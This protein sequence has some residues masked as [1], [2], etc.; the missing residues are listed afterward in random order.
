MKKRWWSNLGRKA[1]FVLT[2]L[3]TLPALFY[4]E[5]NW[6]GARAWTACQRAL[7]AQGES[8]D[9][10]VFLG[11]PVPLE[12][13]LATLPVFTRWGPY[14]VEPETGRAFFEHEP[15]MEIFHNMPG[16]RAKLER[17]SPGTSR[18]DLAAWQ[19]YFQSKH[20]GTAPLDPA[21]EVLQGLEPFETFLNELTAARG[22]MPTGQFRRE[23]SLAH[24]DGS[25]ASVSADLRVNF[26][27]LLRAKAL[28]AA[29]HPDEAMRDLET[30][31]WLRRA[32]YSHPPMLLPLMMGTA[33]MAQ[34]YLVMKPGMESGHWTAEEI[35]RLQKEL[36][37]V[38][39]LADYVHAM[40]GE[41]AHMLAMLSARPESGALPSPN[42]LWSERL[43][44]LAFLSGPSGWIDQNKANLCQW[45]QDGPLRA[46]D[47][48]GHRIYPERMAAAHSAVEIRHVWSLPYRYITANFVYFLGAQLF[49]VADTQA[50]TDELI[51]TCALER[52]ALTHGGRIPVALTELVP[53]FLDRLPTNIFDGT[54]PRYQIRP[55]GSYEL[56]IKRPAK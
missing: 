16:A 11:P 19:Q 53:H 27:L 42:E 12:R 23:Y 34:D 17:S 49:V 13:N 36:E 52:Y 26:T 31:C 18:F 46:C 39:L 25:Y 7:A 22:T 54:P 15:L 20:P 37:G 32:L 41:R 51:V 38:D 33:L 2:L 55:D 14:T 3:T 8:L 6:R 30:A 48:P 35:A 43:F 50:Q 4:A 10:A 21:G 28:L 44:R 56:T 9:R 1:I 29:N 40:R 24:R 45:F 5:E 47:I